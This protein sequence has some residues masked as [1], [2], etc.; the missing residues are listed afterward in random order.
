V[1]ENGSIVGGVKNDEF[2]TNV[3]EWIDPATTMSSYDYLAQQSSGS[4][5]NTAAVCTIVT[6]V[7]IGTAYVASQLFGF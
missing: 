1:G 2:P 5:L 4:M 6:V 7:G 3:G